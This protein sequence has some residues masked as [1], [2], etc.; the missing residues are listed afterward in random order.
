MAPPPPPAP[1]QLPAPVATATA[2]ASAVTPAVA[3]V[4]EEEEK[5]DDTWRQYFNEDNSS[6]DDSGS[7]EDSDEM[8]ESE[9][10]TADRRKSDMDVLL[11]QQ[12]RVG[13]SSRPSQSQRERPSVAA[14]SQEAK[15][16]SAEKPSDKEEE[17]GATPSTSAAGKKEKKKSMISRLSSGIFGSENK[18]GQAESGVVSL[19]KEGALQNCDETWL[20]RWAPRLGK[21]GLPCTKVA[22]NGKP[23]ERRVHVDARNMTMEI[24]GG[25]TGAT[26]VL[27]DDLVDVRLGIHSPEFFKF[28][29]R[30][31]K[32]FEQAEIMKRAV[33][34]QTPSRT[35]SFL[36]ST[37]NQRDTV[38][39]YVVYL[40][41]S[42]N[43]GVMASGP[44]EK[45]PDKG[46]K[47][48]YG[49]VTYPTRSSYEGQF[50]QYMRHGKGTLTLSDGTKYE[51]DWRHD[52]RHGE[53]K[54]YWADGTVFSGT[55][56]KGMR[57]GHGVMT[58]PEGSKYSGQFERGRANGEGELVRT[59]GSVYHGLFSE[60]CM[61]GEGRMQWRDGVEYVGQF[62]GNRREGFGRMVWTTGRWKSYE[63]HWKDG[64]QHG[65]GTLVDRN[66]SE[67][68]GT[69][70]NGKLDRWD[71]DL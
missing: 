31:K 51:C 47:D 71:D 11:R 50:Q 32:D 45:S 46:V 12:Q 54:E 69:F 44:T 19:M 61:C 41:K 58:W 4:E 60:D 18:M 8:P 63:G 26:G 33:V 38:S 68:S 52:E 49:T 39:Q 28:A 30:F 67:F 1:G 16:V 5:G 15:E 29:A 66:D 56:V 23:Y 64:V 20:Q 36:F 42:N 3:A 7:G 27:L 10:A 59:D 43:R 48:G 62:V 14:E 55:Y 65:H 35:F 25:R 17:G 70:C 6:E 34:L 53:G 22:T 37:E 24:R 2:A 40:L 21:D 57:S 9:A 13:Y